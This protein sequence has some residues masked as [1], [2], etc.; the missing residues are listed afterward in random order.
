MTD[1]SE[2]N[3]SENGSY[4]ERMEAV[5]QLLVKK[6]SMR[7]VEL[8]EILGVSDMTV[9]RCLNAM[10]A[11]GLIRRFHGGAVLIEDAESRYSAMRHHLNT[12]IKAL[13]A[14]KALE[15]MPEN[16]S[17]YLDSGTTCF[18][19]V[20]RLAASDKKVNI[21]TDSFKVVHE[22]KSASTI[23][24]TL[25][26]G[27][28]SDDMT[29]LDGPFAADAASRVTL[30]VCFFSADSFDEERLDNKYLG[31][32]TT[33]KILLSRSNRKIFV[34]DSTKYTRRC[35]FLFCGWDDVDIFL[36]DSF[37]PVPAKK[38]I[39]GKGV[40]IITVSEPAAVVQ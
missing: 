36:T 28:L 34:A 37:L 6:G 12:N 31:G 21:I 22:L 11:D 5:Y 39:A 13:L 10:A 3:A 24:A 27:N 7:V 20:K 1:F 14:E 9:R 17:I 15:F 23:N 40:E 29:T 32:A 16:A 38:S 33:R 18:A 19:I 26:G 2:N 4:R 25:L 8:Q 35:C 30:D